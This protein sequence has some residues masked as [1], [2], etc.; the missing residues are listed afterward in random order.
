MVKS[1]KNDDDIVIIGSEFGSKLRICGDGCMIDFSQPLSL[2]GIGLTQNRR[3]VIKRDYNG[4]QID[5]FTTIGVDVAIK[6]MFKN[7]NIFSKMI[8]IHSRA[9]I[10]NKTNQN[11]K[12]R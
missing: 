4:R 9:I 7:Q 11:F 12:L 10:I 2:G 8:T 1:D 3:I 6:K 5:L